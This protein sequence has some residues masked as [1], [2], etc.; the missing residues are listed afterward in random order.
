MI[1]QL[2][3]PAR[4]QRD[5]FQVDCR[6]WQLASRVADVT[7]APCPGH[8][9]SRIVV[10]SHRTEAVFLEHGGVL[11]RYLLRIEPAGGTS[12]QIHN[13]MLSRFMADGERVSVRANPTDASTKAR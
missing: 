4:K 1:L 11:F 8:P 7:A 3:K 12:N 5:G 2:D 6:F 9:F 10:A 13:E